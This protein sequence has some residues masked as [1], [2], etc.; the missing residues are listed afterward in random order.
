MTI[1]KCKCCLI[2]PKR[3][4]PFSLEKLVIFNLLNS[5]FS[6]GTPDVSCTLA[7]IPN[8]FPDYSTTLVETSLFLHFSVE[9][10]IHYDGFCYLLLKC[11]H[12]VCNQF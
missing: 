2:L 11:K 10:L 5:D 12:M 1:R 4:Y 7:D 3:W 6:E 9:I 8:E